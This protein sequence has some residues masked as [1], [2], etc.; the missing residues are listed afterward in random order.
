M[1]H[2]DEQQIEEL[3]EQTHP[4]TTGRLEKQLAR[5]PWTVQA[6]VRRRSINTVTF[7]VLMASLTFAATPQG[8]AL[9]QS[10]LQFFTRAESNTF[11]LEPSQ[12]VPSEVASSLSTAEPP[13]PIIRVA[14]AEEQAGFD[15]AELPFIPKGFNYLGARLYG[16]AISIEYEAQG[17]GGYLIIKQSQHGFVQS[18]W[19]QVPAEAIVPVKIGEIDAEFAEG[20][21]VVYPGETSAK[22][23]PNAALL[24]LR[25]VKDGVYFE[26]TKF[27]DVEPIEYLNQDTLIQ[28]AESINT[29]LFPLDVNSTEARA[30]FDTL[31]P[32]ALPEGMTFLGAS[33]DPIYSLASLSYGYPPED[34]RILIK[35]QPVNSEEICELCGIVGAS[36]AVQTVQIGDVAGEYAEGVWELTDNGPVWHDDPYLKTI[37]WQKDG[38]AFELVFMGMEL[39]RDELVGI[40][41]SL[42]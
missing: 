42:H 26:M 1:K 41:A 39:D 13:A 37:R 31:E 25:W 12:I 6:V 4:Q 14:E 10:V 35:Q 20:T 7:L 3:L 30:G 18:E 19:D 40:A 21:F 27:G 11:P 5:A 15:A 32:A 16:K 29:E 23:N 34:G 22:W 36:A 33:F 8:R 17:G 38:M 2:P 9:A 28:L 24:R